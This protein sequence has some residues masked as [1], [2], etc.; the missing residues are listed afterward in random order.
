MSIQMC[1]ESASD[2]DGFI[3]RKTLFDSTEN[4]QCYLNESQ[5][6]NTDWRLIIG[7]KIAPIHAFLQ[8]LCL[9]QRF[10]RYQELL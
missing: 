10:N 5:E 1:N 2:T 3:D 7:N 4:N 8:Q 6:D 9:P